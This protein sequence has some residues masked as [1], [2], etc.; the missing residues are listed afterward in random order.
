MKIIQ[1]IGN[2]NLWDRRKTLFLTSKLAPF[3]TY[4]S[5]FNWVDSLTDRDTI[6]CFNT[7]ELEAEVV[8]ALLVNN[9]PT[10]LV[11]MDY[12]HDRYNVQI[13]K[14]LDE[15]RI[16]I[17]VLKREKADGRGTTPCLRNKFIIGQVQHTVCGYVNP[18]GSII[19]ILNNNSNITYL[20]NDKKLIAA[21]DETKSFRWSVAEDK[22]LLSMFYNDMGIHAIHMAINRPYSTVYTKIKSLTM[23]DETL[24]G[25]QFEDYIVKM[26]FTKN[27]GELTLKEW[28]GDKSMPG[29]Y[30]SYNSAPDLVLDYKGLP[31]AIECKWRNHIPNSISKDLL[32]KERIDSFLRYSKTHNT[33]IIIV[34]G[35]D[36]MPDN[37]ESI[38]IAPI[39]DRITAK[40][41]Y[42]SIVKPEEI[43]NRSLSLLDNMC[44]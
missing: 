5:V 28:R 23:N 2:K 44:P 15:N 7:S 41:L 36:G 1:T 42:N 8:K 21:E 6:V 25:R 11:V 20:K 31:F 12:F 33:P 30:P 26:L 38:F 10:V 29:I 40:E 32:P 37:P 4:A 22:R 39:K 19:L 35:I 34:L 16:L 9:I 18:K 43:L 17:M 3:S 27:N 24:K 13:N 14:A